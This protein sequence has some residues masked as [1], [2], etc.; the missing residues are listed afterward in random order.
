MEVIMKKILF[1][2]SV[3]FIS[4]TIQAKDVNII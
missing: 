4:F 1:S 3:L 2:I